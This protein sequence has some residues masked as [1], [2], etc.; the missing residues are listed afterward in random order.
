MF[1]FLHINNFGHSNLWKLVEPTCIFY[2]S[3]CS[4][5]WRAWHVAGRRRPPSTR[6]WGLA[7]SQGAPHLTAWSRT[8]S[9][10]A[11]TWSLT[12]WGPGG[13]VRGSWWLITGDKTSSSLDV[14]AKTA[15]RARTAQI[16][17]IAIKTA[18]MSYQRVRIHGSLKPWKTNLLK[19]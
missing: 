4:C 18:K 15:K 5:W 1:H 3:Q 11:S 13:R 6:W 19:L 16:A 9:S 2:L 10:R 8:W 12:S 17:K 7:T 14:T